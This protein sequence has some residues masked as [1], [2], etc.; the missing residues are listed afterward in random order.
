MV[1][2]FL[3]QIERLPTCRDAYK[4]IIIEAN[5]SYIS[6]DEIA[7]WC[8]RPCYTNMIIES[9]D[10]KRLG[11]SGVWTGPYEKEA[12]SY[13]LREQIKNLNLGFAT[14]LVGQEDKKE[15]NIEELIK[16]LRVFRLERSIPNDPGFGKYKYTFT[17]K[18]AGGQKDDR[19]LA[20]MMAVYWAQRYRESEHTKIWARQHGVDMHAA[21]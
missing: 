8:R 2:G 19:V 3:D 6:A 15:K 18:T 4:H 7:S 11:R 16:Q 9:R 13:Q 1:C 12:Y 17:G 20:L 10:S 21:G 5:M 14:L